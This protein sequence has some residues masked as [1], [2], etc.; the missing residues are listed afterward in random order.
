MSEEQEVLG[1]VSLSLEQLKRKIVDSEL[2]GV[3]TPVALTSAFQR[4]GGTESDLDEAVRSEAAIRRDEI[5]PAGLAVVWSRLLH[6]HESLS[7]GEIRSWVGIDMIRALAAK[8]ATWSRFSATVLADWARKEST[9]TTENTLMEHLI[10]RH[11]AEAAAVLAQ[12]M[13]EIPSGADRLTHRL[14]AT[15]PRTL[16]GLANAIVDDSSIP[17]ALRVTLAGRAGDQVRARARAMVA[18]ELGVTD[19]TLAQLAPDDVLEEEP[20]EVGEGATPAA[21]RLAWFWAGLAFF[22]GT[23][24]SLRFNL[25]FMVAAVMCLV[26]WLV[27]RETKD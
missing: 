19:A 24:L 20:E 6:A 21:M 2:Q 9:S 23:V 25:A 18:R 22:L 3:S 16:A 26:A 5:T 15:S 13:R 4:L 8:S 17:A 1:D 12:A 7:E 11:P 10:A 14:E 27:G